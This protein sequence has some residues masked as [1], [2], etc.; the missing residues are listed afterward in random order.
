MN[1]EVEL[2]LLGDG[3]LLL[4]ATTVARG[5]LGGCAWANWAGGGEL[6]SR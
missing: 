3:T 1:T 6:H 2:D 4:I 5:E